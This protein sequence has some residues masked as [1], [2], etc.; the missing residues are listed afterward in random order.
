[1]YSIDMVFLNI[2]GRGVGVA[3]CH[4]PNTPQPR[5]DLSRKVLLKALNH[6][7]VTLVV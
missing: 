5:M 4:T 2:R 7:N 1:L 6:Y 3:L